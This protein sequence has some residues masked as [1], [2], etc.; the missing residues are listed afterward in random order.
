[1]SI[2]VDA[3]QVMEPISPVEAYMLRNLTETSPGVFID[4]ELGG[5][6]S[7]LGGLKGPWR[8]FDSGFHTGRN[9]LVLGDSFEL[10]FVPFLM[11][12]YDRIIVTDLRDSLYSAESSGASVRE[13]IE[14]YGV[15]DIYMLYS[16]Y[17]PFCGDSVQSR[18]RDCL[19]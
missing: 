7:Y 12:Y 4:R 15:T 17:S 6:M 19:D 1:M 5:L 8:L 2:S 3:V 10:T 16:T 13:Y 18:L 14:T 9:A 11:P